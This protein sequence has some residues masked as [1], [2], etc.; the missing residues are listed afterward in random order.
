MSGQIS[1][2][3][4]Y[5]TTDLAS[6]L[7]KIINGR[8]SVHTIVAETIGSGLAGDDGKTIS[9]SATSG[10]PAVLQVALRYPKSSGLTGP[11]IH[12]FRCFSNIVETGG[13]GVLFTDGVWITQPDGPN[14]P[15]TRGSVATFTIFYTGGANA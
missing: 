9:L 13:N 12:D 4:V 6:D 11:S 10:G 2:C 5:N 1:F 7:G 3:N 14:T 8:V 15:G